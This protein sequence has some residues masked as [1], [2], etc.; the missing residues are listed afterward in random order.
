MKNMRIV[1]GQFV[2]C[3]Y[4]APKAHL[5]PIHYSLFP[6]GGRFVNRPYGAIAKAG[7]KHKKNTNS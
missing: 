5:L 6:E 1:G 2:N 4:G 7:A 3:P